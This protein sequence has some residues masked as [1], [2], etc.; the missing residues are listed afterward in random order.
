VRGIKRR[1]AEYA[2]FFCEV[3][4][5]LTDKEIKALT[6]K[7]KPYKI[8][9]GQGLYIEVAKSGSKIW[10]AKYRY[11]GREKRLTIG[12]WPRVSIHEARKAV[13]AAKD[14]LREGDDPSRRK[15][16]ATVGENFRDIALDWLERKLPAW[17]DTHAA[18]VKSRLVHYIFPQIG[19]ISMIKITPPD[20]LSF[21]RGIERQ[22]KFETA[23]R[24][25]E[26]TSQVMRYGVACGLIPSDPCRDLRGAL[27]SHRSRPM[28]A[29]TSE[30]DIAGLMASI[31]EYSGSYTVKTAMLWSIYLFQRPGNIRRARWD[32]IN[33]DKCLWTIPTNE[34]KNRRKHIV[35]LP[36]QCME[37][38]KNIRGG[39][40]SPEWV[41]PGFSASRPLSENG[42]LSALRRMGYTPQEMTAHGFRALAK[43]RLSEMIG[44]G[45]FQHV[46]REH[47]EKQ[48]AHASADRIEDIYNRSEYVDERREMLQAWCNYLDNL[49]HT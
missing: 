15:R 32:Q 4:T 6:P 34:M 44:K 37:I 40:F 41:F 12:A 38:L 17:S 22:R 14:V 42:V 3:T 33:Y 18:T 26:I 31:R 35:P 28:A 16:R 8:S 5:M 11:Q 10:R 20:V 9:D 39:K 7:E 21:V 25:L 49:A 13:L 29:L 2:P 43:T 23:S 30:E 24:V 45:Q 1:K 46:R 47:V 27:T 19:D 48:L 36:T